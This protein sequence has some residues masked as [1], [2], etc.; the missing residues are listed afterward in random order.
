MENL[1]P[2]PEIR[3]SYEKAGRVACQ[4]LKFGAKQVKPGV[5]MREVLDSIE[6]YIIKHGCGIA[7]PAQSSINNVAAHFCPLDT[8][9]VIY[10]DGDVVKLDIGAHHEGFIGDNAITISVGG[11][12]KDLV[13]ASAAAV[14][15]AQGVLKPGC[16]PNDVG[17][18]VQD[19]I[20]SRGFQPVR[21][22]SGHGVGR[23]R[24]HTSPGMPNYPTGEGLQLVEH[25]VIAIE[26][27]A[28]TGRAGLIY[29]GTNATLF[30]LIN[31]KPLRS[32]YAREVYSLVQ[33]YNGLPFTTRW[34]TRKLGGKAMLG[35][36]E[37]RRAGMLA[38]Y[39]P[40]LDKN[41]G[42]VSQRENTFMIT[43]TGC[44]V[45]TTDD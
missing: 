19:A 29:N 16:T 15:A 13:D 32:P 10:N 25:Q 23:F 21:N 2:T 22:L 33:S 30:A 1:A 43:K 3:K 27:F 12:H 31:R 45:L 18:A 8:E 4:A 11:E 6:E 41:A 20:V 40:L 5:N 9:E 24:I 38:E 35:L 42:L 7:F 44:K 36:S 17:K 28:T 14:K 37:M 26:P 34:L 39:P